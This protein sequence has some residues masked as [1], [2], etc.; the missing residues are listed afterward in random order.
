MF[1]EL[2]T[3]AF[4]LAASISWGA[5]DFSGGL[6]TRRAQVLSVVIGAYVVGL[7]MLIAL[8]FIW[9]EPFPSTLDL[10]WGS[11][12]GLAGA[13]GLVAFYQA[14]AVGRMGIVAPIAAMLSAAVPV[15]FGA[16]IEGLPAPIQLIGFVLAFIAVGLISGLGVVKGRPEGLRLALLAGPSQPWS[17]FLAT[18]CCKA[19]FTSL[20]VCCC[21]HPATEG[22]TREVSLARSIFSRSAGRGR[23]CILRT[24]YSYWTTR[25]CRD[26]LFFVPCGNRSTGNNNSQRTCDSITDY[27]Y[28]FCTGGDS[29]DLLMKC[30]GRGL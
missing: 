23:Q 5:G 19:L 7:I 24:R 16:L 26:S 20:F 13:V 14:L 28:I 12:A 21:T 8:A 27:W 1:H 25:C 15:L 3:V 9:S 4:A 11:V 18:C 22:S 6:A 10:M 2:S 29:I 17:C 30:T